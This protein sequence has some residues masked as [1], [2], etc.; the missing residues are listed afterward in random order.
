MCYS[1]M[2]LFTITLSRILLIQGYPPAIVRNTKRR[3]Y[4]QVLAAADRGDIEPFLEFI[5]DSMLDTQRVILQEL[6]WKLTPEISPN[7][8]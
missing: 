7:R 4:L 1:R 6:H 2:V 5:A 3:V 8:R